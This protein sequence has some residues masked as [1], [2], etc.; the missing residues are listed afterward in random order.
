MSIAIEVLTANHDR[1]LESF[2]DRL[3]A[4][5]PSVLGYH[6]PFYRDL[7]A[8]AGAGESRYLGARVEGTLVGVLPAFKI[9]SASGSAYSSLPFFGP[10][11]GAL[12][13]ADERSERICSALLD[14]FLD[15][16]RSDGALSCSIYT[17]FQCE[18][19]A[20]YDAA[21]P[22][23]HVVEKFTQYLD[24]HSA[25][26]SSAIAYDLRKGKRLGVEI[27]KDI[28]TER[29]N[30]FYE[31]YHMNCVEYGIPIKPKPCV[32]LLFGESNLGQHSDAYFAMRDGEMIG[33]L[34]MVWSP[35]TAS[36]YIPCTLPSARTLQPGTLLIDRAVQD[37]RQRGIHYWNWEASPSRESGVFQ[38][39]KKWGS[40]EGRYRIYVQAFKPAEV[41]RALGRATIERDFPFFFV[42]P[43]D[44]L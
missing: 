12:T 17:P 26:W 6:Y 43:F 28:T 35:L 8:T 36:Y 29:I 16:A 20:C 39:K 41:F 1:E 4:V 5:S 30:R 33:G 25:T 13:A 31:L 44:R 42:Y 22:E 2:L 14:S 37:A 34:L 23:A 10:N 15:Y 40:T 38:F 9:A 32:D 19:L 18:N 11:A 27:S 24:L 3:G 21:M 7:I